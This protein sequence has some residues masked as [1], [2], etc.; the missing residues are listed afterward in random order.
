MTRFSANLALLVLLLARPGIADDTGPLAAV[1]TFFDAM[2][3]SDVTLA[4][5]VMVDDGILYGYIESVDGLRLV[6]VSIGEFLA[7]WENRED[8]L[9]ERIWD[10]QVLTHDRLAVVWTPYDFFLNGEFHHCGVNSFNL[11]R[12]DAGWKIT[13]VTYSMETATCE[14][15]PLGPPDFD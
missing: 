10:V 4:R 9:L 6:R 11:I 5:S 3:E 7:G 14:E 13:G 15:S 8:S 1:N 12:S 2:A